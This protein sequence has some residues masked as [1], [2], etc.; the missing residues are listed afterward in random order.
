MYRYLLMLSAIL[1]LSLLSA[2]AFSIPNYLGHRGYILDSNNEAITGVAE[3]TFSLYAA[4]DDNDTIWQ[5]TL[6]LNFENGYYYVVLGTVTPIEADLFEDDLYLGIT[7]EDNDEF[8]PRH[9]LTAVPYAFKALKADSVEG[10]VNGTDGLHINGTRVIDSEGAWSGDPM[11]LWTDGEGKV[12]TDVKVGIG[13]TDPGDYE[14]NV[15]GNVDISG[16]LNLSGSIT[17]PLASTSELP[18]PG[19][20]AGQMYFATD[21]NQIYYS[22]GTD[23]INIASQ[24][25]SISGIEPRLIELEQDRTINITG[26]SFDPNVTVSFGSVTSPEVTVLSAGNLTATTGTELE[27][28]IHDVTLENPNGASDT[29]IGGLIVNSPPEWQ[30]P[31]GSLGS[32]LELSDSGWTTPLVATDPDGGELTYSVVSGSLPG[33]LSLDS[34]SGEITGTIDSV[35][36]DTTSNF[37]V[38]VTDNLGIS[39]ERSFS[40]TNQNYEIPPDYKFRWQFENNLNSDPRADGEPVGPNGVSY[41]TVTYGN[42]NRNMGNGETKTGRFVQTNNTKWITFDTITADTNF[43]FCVW[44]YQY[45]RHGSNPTFL[46]DG[47]SNDT[48]FWMN[49]ASANL[50]LHAPGGPNGSTMVDFPAQAWTH[51]CFTRD[52][53][54]LKTYK[55]G[56]LATTFTNGGSSNWFF[57]AI[58][59]CCG[60]DSNNTYYINAGWDEWFWYERTLSD[61]EILMLYQNT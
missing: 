8:S 60:N 14:L 1:S 4:V 46:G 23:W 61:S 38:A 28:G 51:I 27:S 13:T 30:T 43:S 15:N 25:P 47:A 19:A 55:N 57:E 48:R 45:S 49:G 24:S 32:V 29:F 53:N 42:V 37:T 22:N 12:T 34:S 41:G 36:E 3:T 11:S 35:D 31:E 7:F 40:I 20:S 2:S 6:N 59:H 58:G 21:T 39:V 5:E 52:G 9:Q 18:D 17:L 10:H 54:N 44:T 33:G 56:N 50:M 26:S 16:N